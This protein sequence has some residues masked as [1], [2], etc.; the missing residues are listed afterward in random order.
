MPPNFFIYH[1]NK[2]ETPEDIFR[3]THQELLKRSGEWLSNIS[4]ASSVVAGLF[5]TV[6][7]NSS[8]EEPGGMNEGTGS[9]RFGHL[10][11]F[12]IFA[13]FSLLGFYSSVAAVILF[14]AILSSGYREKDFASALPRKLLL[15]LTMLYFSIACT[16]ISFSAGHV[17]INLFC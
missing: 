4:Q 12:K 15:G 2:G 16:L 1:N 11:G 17:F 9:P 13:V 8:V 10:S 14:L 7:Y 6:T 5:V 3:R